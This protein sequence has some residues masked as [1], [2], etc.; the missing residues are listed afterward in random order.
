MKCREC[1]IEQEEDEEW[2]P[3]HPDLCYGCCICFDYYE[4]YEEENK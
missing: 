4:D 1:G 3:G 2:H